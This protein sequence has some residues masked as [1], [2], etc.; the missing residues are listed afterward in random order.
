[1]ISVIPC[2]LVRTFAECVRSRAAS[3]LGPV[4]PVALGGLSTRFPPNL[5]N[6]MPSEDSA[7]DDGSRFPNKRKRNRDRKRENNRH[8][9]R[10]RSDKDKDKPD[11]S[12]K[13]PE[14]TALG[15]ASKLYR[16]DEI[17]E[18]LEA[19]LLIPWRNNPEGPF[20]DRFDVRNLL[21]SL[22]LVEDPEY[23][24]TA[25][26]ERDEIEEERY[27]ELND[28]SS[29]DERGLDSKKQ[30]TAIGF[31]YSPAFLPTPSNPLPPISQ[32]TPPSDPSK[33]TSK[34]LEII[35]RTAKFINSSP[36][37]AQAEIMIQAKQAGNPDFGFLNR[38]DPLYPEF[39]RQVQ[40]LK[41]GMS[42]GN[43]GSEEEGESE[44][45]VVVLKKPEIE[46]EPPPRDE[47]DELITDIANR[48]AATPSLETTL[49][50]SH[51]SNPRFSFLE[52]SDPKHGTYLSRLDAAKA[53]ARL[54]EEQ[55]EV[56]FK[57][58][59]NSSKINEETK[60]ERLKRAREFMARK[61][62]AANPAVADDDPSTPDKPS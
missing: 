21:E 50:T 14:F 62:A 29:D 55:V 5:V 19:E 56:P 18:K 57:P 45:V 48:V 46:R 28:D 30:G 10:Q 31:S 40:L 20:L 44:E 11:S 4:V 51:V 13:A 25:S 43:S 42:Y 35:Q 58:I 16:D 8:R 27:R 12:T 61:K 7:S 24:S 22:E 53:Q 3:F 26:S 49:R 37:P 34:Q 15:Y 23:A 52:P 60:E 59:E 41:L 32:P 47:Q 36:N 54:V 38:R 33:P 1:M 17:A 2:F 9:A 39:Q 6:A